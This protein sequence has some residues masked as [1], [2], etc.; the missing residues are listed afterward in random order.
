MLNDLN[1]HLKAIEFSVTEDT[2]II[3]VRYVKYSAQGS[4]TQWF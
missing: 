3:L 2:V 4:D 1:R